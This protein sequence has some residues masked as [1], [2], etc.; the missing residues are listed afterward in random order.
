K[1]NAKE[2]A[3]KKDV[4]IIQSSTKKL[5]SS[6]IALSEAERIGFPVMLKAASGGGGRGM[7]VIRKADEIKNYFNEARREAKNA[8]G[9]DTMFIEKYVENPKHIE[10]Q[11]VA[12]RHGNIVHLFERDCSV[13]RR[14]QKVVEVAPAFGLPDGVKEELYKHAINITK[15]VG[16]NNVGTVEFLVD[17]DNNIYFIEVNPRIQVEHTVTE[18]VTGIDLIKT[19][20][21]IAAGFKLSS[22]Q[23]KIKS[24]KS[25]KLNGFALQCRITT[26]DPKENFKPDYG[27]IITYRSAGGFGIRLDMG[28]LYAGVK[29]SPFF[30]SM[31][32][33]V[34]A[35]SR[36]LDGAC[37]KMERALKEFQIRGVKHNIQFLQNIVT[38][39]TFRDG[40]VNVGF[41]DSD[42]SLFKFNY[43][44]DRATKIVR[45]LGHI[46]VN[47]NSDVKFIDREKK[48]IKPIIPSFDKHAPFPKGTKDLLTKLGPEKFAEKIK[49]DKQIHYTDTTFRDAHQ[50]LLATRMRSYD[51]NA[52]AEAYARNHPNIFSMEVWGG[53]TFDVCLRFLHEN[54]WRRLAE[55]RERMPNVLLQML[56]RGSNGVGYS[57]YPDNLVERF[58][59][60]SWNTGVDVFRVFDSLN[61]MKNMEP[62]IKFV[63][64]RTQGIAEG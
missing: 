15:A 9:D 60:E 38:H 28:S 55:L 46:V 51:L 39:E 62:C 48:F 40:K 61:W 59:E 36:T 63:R 57:A 56:I 7:R 52:V 22:E 19:Q 13:Q 5:T 25:L 35:H 8:F 2:T 50:S 43:K 23:I 54:P 41:I 53:A 49:K 64:E 16:Y 17:P 34:S 47:G 29:I 31:L 32:V 26:E 14:F 24:Q 3:T 45:Y 37:R 6:K 30:D 10:I 12:D 33:K 44:L 21:F 1:I 27:T 20:I 58:V 42:K 18:M 4:P 11:I